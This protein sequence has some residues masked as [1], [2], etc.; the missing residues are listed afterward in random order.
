MRR[1]MEAD[2]NRHKASTD[3]DWQATE[4]LSLHGNGEFT[5]DDYLNSVYGLKK[6]V[7][8][9]ASL[10]AS[11]AP[12]E[13][14]VADVFYTYDNR[15]LLTR[16][17][18]YGSNSTSSSVGQSADTAVSGGCFATVAS[19]NAS[20]KIDPCLNWP[21]NNRDKDD[22]F[23]LT[24]SRKNLLSGNLELA[25][26]VLYTRGRTDTAVS[27][28]SYVNNPLALASPAP[29]LPSGTAAVNFIPAANYP[30]VRD[31]EITVSPTAQYLIKKRATLRA[32]YL[33]Q[34]MMS[35]DWIYLG[36]Q[37]G[38]GTNYLPSNERAPNY[39]VS[40]GGLSL[41]FAF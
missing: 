1:Y 24:I 4:K 13:N 39:A 38:T 8:W 14:L 27:G 6:D 10:D 36:M 17:D 5:D 41:I 32:Y 2:R 26:Q 9:E 22:T 20:A 30:T 12:S 28:G 21:K 23:G 11:Y 16:G 18:A 19:K 25:A 15:R 29:A 35:S 3:M 40:A 31:D 7:F 37:Y 34:R 33:F